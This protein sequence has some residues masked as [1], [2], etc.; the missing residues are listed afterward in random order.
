MSYVRPRTR[1]AVGMLL[2]LM[3][4]VMSALAAEDQTKAAAHPAKPA[5]RQKTQPTESTAAPTEGGQRP[6]PFDEQ[7]SQTPPRPKLTL[8]AGT[9]VPVRLAETLDTKH[10]RAGDRFSATLDAPITLRGRVVVPKGTVFDG[11]VTQSQASG[12]LRGR[13]VLGLALDSFRLRGTTYRV[14]TAADFRKSNG[15]GKRNAA[16]IGG[17]T[18]IGAVLGKISGVGAAI[19]AGAGAA[20]GTTTALVTGKRNVKLPVET[21]LVFSLRSSVDV[22]S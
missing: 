11:H 4:P 19:G 5:A 16:L 10:V 20:A 6:S 8:P 22:R 14:R 9:E 2:T 3:V 21:P 13:G 7:K 12:R 18:A 17:G 1:S 15:H